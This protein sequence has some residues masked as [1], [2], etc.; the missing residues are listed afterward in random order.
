VSDTSDSAGPDAP[1]T[2]RIAAILASGAP[3]A[4]MPFPS[5]SDPA[6]ARLLM[7][8]S[9]RRALDASA[10]SHGVATTPKPPPIG[11]GGGGK[12]PG[13]SG[14][15]GSASAGAGS[16][17]PG[18]LSSALWF[19]MIVAGLALAGQELRRHRL[20]LTLSAPSGFTPLLQRPG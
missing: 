18:G 10:A 6:M 14:P 17:A 16:A 13:P 8:P 9:A 15:P 11:H 1:P 5:G 7:S 20:R 19:V 3:A 4:L 12:G 2:S